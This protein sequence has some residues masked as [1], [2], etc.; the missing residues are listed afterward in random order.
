MA[1]TFD[2]DNIPDTL[3]AWDRALHRMSESDF[4]RREQEEAEHSL[5]LSFKFSV[6]QCNSSAFA[7][8]APMVNVYRNGSKVGR[9]V[10]TVGEVLWDAL[11]DKAFRERAMQVLMEAAKVNKEAQALLDQAAV[12]WAREA[13]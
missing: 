2:L 1:I 9:R 4:L 12:K 10:Q 3:G 8:F 6:A 7:D 11:D 13:V 5:C